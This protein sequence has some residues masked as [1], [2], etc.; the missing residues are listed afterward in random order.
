MEGRVK[1]P[2][3]RTATRPFLLVMDSEGGANHRIN[4]NDNC[5]SISRISITEP[6]L[7]S[8]D[9]ANQEVHKYPRSR[10]M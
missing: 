2:F 5:G 6:R 9:T 7:S 10:R 8:L 3:G 4:G 1:L